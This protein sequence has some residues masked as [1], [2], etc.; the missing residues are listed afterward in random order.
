MRKGGALMIQK[1]DTT[2]PVVNVRKTQVDSTQPVVNVRSTKT[3]TIQPVS[4]PQSPSSVKDN[5]LNAKTNAN[6]N[7]ASNVNIAGKDYTL[8]YANDPANY[9]EMRQ[10]VVGG[11]NQIS[12]SDKLGNSWNNTS[13]EQT[14]FAPQVPQPVQPNYSFLNDA[15]RARQLVIDARLQ[16]SLGAQAGLE[17]DAQTALANKTE[18][19][20]GDTYDAQ[21][22]QRATGTQRGIQY[23]QQ[24][25]GIEAGIS[26]AGTKMI[27]DA[28]KD[29][30]NAILNIKDRIASLKSGASYEKQ[31]STAQADAEK[32]K[33]QYEASIRGEDRQWQ[34]EDTQSAR[35]YNNATIEK[36]WTHD[37]EV[38]YK[39]WTHDEAVADKA[40]TNQINMMN[41]DQGNKKELMGLEFG[42]KKEFLKLETATQKEILDIKNKYDVNMFGLTSA[43]QVKIQGMNNSTQM[44][45]GQLSANTQASIAK[46]GRDQNESQFNATINAEKDKV[47]VDMASTFMRNEMGFSFDNPSD[48][49][50]FYTL[51]GMPSSLQAQ[52]IKGT[53]NMDSAVAQTAKTQGVPVNALLK[54][55]MLTK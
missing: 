31:A 17:R 28:G 5:Y 10:A 34:L 26:R 2:Q 33:L 9:E 3:D 24:Q 29:R 46:A 54:K 43:L 45:L 7:T 35:D 51:V 53:I 14:T 12:V 50:R 6:I 39:G 25:Q 19:I 23:S 55:Y 37:D 11:N 38:M 21:E 42:Q 32:G 27:V 52:L 15:D 18:Q 36:G 49:K 1:F 30:D 8:A 16:E 48:A 41:I 4:I 47:M 44:A 40:Y 13:G 20:Q 22:S